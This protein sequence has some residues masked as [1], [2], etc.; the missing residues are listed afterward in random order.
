MSNEFNISL[1][2]WPKHTNG[3]CQPVPWLILS[4]FK[5]PFLEKVVF[6]HGEALFYRLLFM[7]LCFYLSN[8]FN[9][10]LLPFSMYNKKEC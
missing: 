5:P 10:C 6:A 1:L 4:F 3:E 2:P 9:F 8:Y 7:F